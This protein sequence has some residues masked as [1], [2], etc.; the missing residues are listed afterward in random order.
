MHCV[1]FSDGYWPG[2]K[3]VLI[4]KSYWFPNLE[5]DN[6][7]MGFGVIPRPGFTNKVGGKNHINTVVS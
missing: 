5:Q 1:C 6:G 7:E 4:S 2:T 3:S